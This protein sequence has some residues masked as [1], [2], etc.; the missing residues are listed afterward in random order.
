MGCSSDHATRT[1]E[2]SCSS[3]GAA[4]AAKAWAHRGVAHGAA[5]VG[6]HGHAGEGVTYAG[7]TLHKPSF[8]EYAASKVIGGG[9]W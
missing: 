6:G 3:L 1:S 4:I 9:M 7:L 5:C 8:V 2:G